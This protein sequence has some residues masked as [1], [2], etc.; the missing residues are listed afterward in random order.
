M[1]G[2]YE[3]IKCIPLEGYKLDITFA[4]GKNG[5]VDLSY[6]VGKGIFNKWNDYQE[7]SK[8]SINKITKTVSWT[9]DIDLDPISLKNKIN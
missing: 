6:L 9:E 3:I 4:D 7:F 2:E 5:I 1:L 8:V